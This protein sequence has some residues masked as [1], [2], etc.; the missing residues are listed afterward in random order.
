MVAKK[1]CLDFVTKKVHTPPMMWAPGGI[2]R[3]AEPLGMFKRLSGSEYCEL[4]EQPVPR[5]YRIII[6]I[7]QAGPGRGRIALGSVEY[8]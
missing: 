8:R 6:Q 1:K 2:C 7:D 3:V 4:S 5:M